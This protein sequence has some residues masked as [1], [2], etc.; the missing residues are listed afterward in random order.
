MKK[1]NKQAINDKAEE[2][3]NMFKGIKVV[4]TSYNKWTE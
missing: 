3:Y 2:F 1:G 4:D